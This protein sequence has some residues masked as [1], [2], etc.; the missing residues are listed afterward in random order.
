MTL[1]AKNPYVKVENLSRVF[2]LLDCSVD[3][4]KRNCTLV[5]RVFASLRGRVI[6]KI[7]TYSHEILLQISEDIWMATSQF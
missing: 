5:R 3:V 1:P 6:G 4:T 2:P 7:W